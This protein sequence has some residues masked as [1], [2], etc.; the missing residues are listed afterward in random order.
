M[1]QNW[2]LPRLAAGKA[3]LPFQLTFQTAV[4]LSD[5]RQQ[6]PGVEVRYG[7]GDWP[8]LRAAPL[9]TE[10]IGPVASPALAAAAD[11][12]QDLP[13]IALSGPRPGWQEWARHASGRATPVPRLRL[14]SLVQALAAARAGLGVTLASLPL[15]HRDLASG[16]LVQLQGEVLKPVE[17]C[18]LVAPRT[19][20]P[21]RQW[22]Q[23]CAVL[24]DVD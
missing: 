2:L 14:D 10:A 22:D 24:C 9:F 6:E 8:A 5:F 21:Q 11:D 23:L 16:A 15:A 17:T 3:Q 18:W 4:V 13:K 7:K 19:A 1:I 12:W 20:M